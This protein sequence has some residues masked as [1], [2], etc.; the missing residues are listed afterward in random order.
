MR[1]KLVRVQRATAV[2]VLAPVVTVVPGLAASDTDAEV[3][4]WDVVELVAAI[5]KV[6]AALEVAALVS[7]IVASDPESTDTLQLPFL[8]RRS[9][10]GADSPSLAAI[11]KRKAGLGKEIASS[12]EAGTTCVA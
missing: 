8:G 4:Q 9:R 7:P 11:D 12:F 3:E 6:V 5:G 2:D 1:V 10:W